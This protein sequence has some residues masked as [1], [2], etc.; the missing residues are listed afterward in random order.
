MTDELKTRYPKLTGDSEDFLMAINFVW[1]ALE[2]IKETL[3][4]PQALRV[5]IAIEGIA[6]AMVSLTKRH[7]IQINPEPQE[8]VNE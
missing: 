6:D 1:I 7:N 5:A 4:E 2:A 8:P 3:P